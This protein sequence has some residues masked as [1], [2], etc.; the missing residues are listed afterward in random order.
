MATRKKTTKKTSTTAIAKWE[1]QLA[2]QAAAAADQ[3]ASTQVGFKRFSIKGGVLM[4]D[5]APVPNNQMAV[6][7]ADFTNYY[8]VYHEAYDPNDPQPPDC[9]AFGRSEDEMTPHENA[10]DPQAETCAVCPLNEWGSADVGRGKKCRNKRRMMVLPAGDLD[11]NGDFEAE[12]DPT[13]YEN[14]EFGVL[15]IPPTS[16][17]GFGAYVKKVSTKLKRPPHAMFTKVRVMS[18]DGTQFK[19]LFE[20]L[21]PVPNQLIPV[22]MERHDEAREAIGYGW[23]K[24]EEQPKPKK[25]TARKPT[26]KKAATRKKTSKARRSKF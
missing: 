17:P 22:L 1:E 23:A 21:G 5:E 19:V 16:I 9:Y 2:K 15:E 26:A 6:V 25:Q 24:K 4:F 18:D 8:G 20:P 14:E 7:I 11:R 3:E 13:A 10:S 12:E